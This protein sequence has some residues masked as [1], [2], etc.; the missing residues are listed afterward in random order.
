MAPSR[1]EQ[2]TRKR[3]LDRREPFTGRCESDRRAGRLRVQR[4][5]ESSPSLGPRAGTAAGWEHSSAACG[6]IPSRTPLASHRGPPWSLCRPGCRR[7]SIRVMIRPGHGLATGNRLFG[8]GG[9][10]AAALTR[11]LGRILE[12]KPQGQPDSDATPLDSSRVGNLKGDPPVAR[13]AAS[14]L[15]PSPRH[16][17]A[18]TRS[19]GE[20]WR[21]SREPP[22]RTSAAWSPPSWECGSDGS[23]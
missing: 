21:P 16:G 2:P 20:S 1:S 5:S 14:A 18:V 7:P 13:K 6:P 11:S 4:T 8:G 12:G 9:P 3:S 15:R 17:A 23:S 19:R 22:E 10:G